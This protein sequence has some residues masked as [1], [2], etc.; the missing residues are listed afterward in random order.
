MQGALWVRNGGACSAATRV[1][2]AGNM[3]RLFCSVSEGLG[4]IFQCYT[5]NAVTAVATAKATWDSDILLEQQNKG[6]L[7]NTSALVTPPDKQY[8][9]I[10]KQH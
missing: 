7:S 1:S 9:K 4:K 5:S 10:T 8:W 3:A 6:I 2:L